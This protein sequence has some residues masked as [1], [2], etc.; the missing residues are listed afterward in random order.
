[1]FNRKSSQSMFYRRDVRGA[2]KLDPQWKC[3]PYKPE[4]LT[5]VPNTHIEKL[6]VGAVRWFI[7]VRHLLPTWWPAGSGMDLVDRCNQLLTFTCA[8]GMHMPL[9]LHKQMKCMSVCL[10]VDPCS[11]AQSKA[12]AGSPG[13]GVTGNGIGI[14]G[15]LET[16]RDLNCWAFSPAH[17]PLPLLNFSASP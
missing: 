14:S 6:G 2:G 15:H 5:L 4:E 7:R 9:N 12:Y 16:A 10:Q 1:M 17:P 8:C 11:W 3:L 13:A